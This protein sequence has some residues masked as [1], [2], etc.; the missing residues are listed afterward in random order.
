MVFEYVSGQYSRIVIDSFK[1]PDSERFC[2]SSDMEFFYFFGDG[3]G[4]SVN[5]GGRGGAADQ[6]KSIHPQRYQVLILTGCGEGCC[7]S[8]P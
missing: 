6:E 8:M 5:R 1:K 3:V 4:M 7:V 2:A